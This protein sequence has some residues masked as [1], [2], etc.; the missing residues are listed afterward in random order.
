MKKLGKMFRKVTW[1]GMGIIMGLTTQVKSQDAALAQ[2]YLEQQEYQKAKEVYEKIIKKG[3]ESPQVHK[4]YLITLENLKEWNEAEKYLKRQ[5]KRKPDNPYYRI[6]YGFLLEKQKKNEESSKYLDKVINEN[7]KNALETEEVAKYF[8]D[9]KQYEWAEKTYKAARKKNG[10]PQA[11]SFQLAELQRILGN[12][13]GMLEEYINIAANSQNIGALQN[14]LQDNLTT[15]E[16]YDKLEQLLIEKVQQNPN[17]RTFSDLLI[18]FYVQQKDF[19]KAFFQAR[20]IDKRYKLGGEK[21][22]EIGLI[23]MQNKD[24]K[25]ANSAFEYLVKEYPQSPNY[26]VSRRYLI[27]AKEELVKNTYPVDLEQIKS[28]ISDYKQLISEIGRNQ[29]TAEALRNVASLYGFYLDQKDSAVHYLNEAIATARTDN[30]LIAK[31]KIDLGDMYLLKN[32]P[33][34]S[35]LL[36]SQVEKEVKDQPIGYEAKLK[37]AKLSFYKGDFELAQSHL[38]ILKMATSREIANDAMDLSLLIQDNLAM[39]TVGEALKQYANVELLLFQHKNG[40][41]LQKLNEMEAT[42]ASHSLADEI[43]WL[44]AQVY[45]QE[46]ENQRAVE[47]LE[48]IVSNYGYDILSDDAH[49]LMAK[50]Y[51]EKLKEKEKAMQLYQAHLTKYPGSIYVVEARKR[52]RQ[53]R[54]DQVN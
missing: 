54:G 49:F 24:F 53:L 18:W 42:Y 51:E 8:V 11:Y 29:Q 23:S 1:M 43:L 38:D 33:W 19:S 28:L 9:N 52:F 47:K 4:N 20:S 7:L 48:K 35:T 26:P 27:T 37:N 40:E 17:E 10:D 30:Q 46:N 15:P 36:Y 13:T 45:M 31:C 34:E 21:V 12:T 39:D 14:A 22:M 2:Q 3:T 6:D 5:I 41:A 50:L 44:Q 16:D 25:S 32:E